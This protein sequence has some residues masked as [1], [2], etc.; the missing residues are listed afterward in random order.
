MEVHGAN[1]YI[2]DEF[3]KSEANKRTDMYG[4]CIEN[5]ARLV[6]VVIDAVCGVVGSQTVSG[7]EGG[8]GE[9]PSPASQPSTR[10]NTR[11]HTRRWGCASR[12]LAASSTAW[13]TTLTRW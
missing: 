6:L 1:G 4:G 8:E 5:R 12:P 9:R 11:A 13:T 10:P 7:G 2:L 3:L